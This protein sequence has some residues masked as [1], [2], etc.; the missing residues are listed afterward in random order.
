R[1]TDTHTDSLPSPPGLSR[2]P[3]GCPG[4]SPGK[5]K[6]VCVLRSS[7][8]MACGSASLIDALNDRPVHRDAGAAFHEPRKVP[9]VIRIVRQSFS[10]L[11]VG[12][13]RR[14]VDETHCLV[15]WSRKVGG[16]EI[17][18]NS[19]AVALDWASLRLD[20]GSEV[21]E[22]VGIEIVADAQCDHCDPPVF[23]LSA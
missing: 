20:I 21:G 15:G 18:D 23:N 3:R 11:L 8:S 2:G 10:I 19:A 6:Y 17:P 7:R 4:T 14:Q 9:L 5:T 22:L 12:R 16:Q 1:G 13:E